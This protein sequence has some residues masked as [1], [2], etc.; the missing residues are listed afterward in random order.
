MTTKTLQPKNPEELR[1]AK[2]AQLRKLRDRYYKMEGEGDVTPEEKL[3]L[4]MHNMEL[5]M[6]YDRIQKVAE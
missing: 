1:Q 4:R 3:H 5:Q 2:L 6:R